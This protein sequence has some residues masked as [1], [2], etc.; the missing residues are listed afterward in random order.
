MSQPPPGKPK[1]R[2]EA[3]WVEK[4]GIGVMIPTMLAATMLVASIMGY[5]L[6]LWLGTKPWLFLLFLIFGF[7]AAVR[8][9]IRMVKRLDDDK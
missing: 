6:D 1:R 9:V 3:S 8:E 5:Y 7:A 4:A 2:N